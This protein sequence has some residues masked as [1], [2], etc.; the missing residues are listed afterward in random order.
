MCTPLGYR[1]PAVALFLVAAAVVVVFA[2]AASLVGASTFIWDPAS[3]ATS[4]RL[5]SMVSASSPGRCVPIPA[6]LTLCHGIKYSQMR[7]PNLLHHDTLGEAIQQSETWLPLTQI[8]CHPDTQLFL[9]S[10]FTPV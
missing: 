9:C 5:P 6:N 2:S 7:L 4:W 8:M 3:N 1:S 10:L